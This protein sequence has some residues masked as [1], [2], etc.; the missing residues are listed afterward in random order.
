MN[1]NGR[2]AWIRTSSDLRTSLEVSRS[3]RPRLS[4]PCRVLA[5]LRAREHFGLRR[6]PTIHRFPATKS[7]CVS[8]IRSRLPLRGSPGVAPGSLCSLR[9]LREPAYVAVYCGVRY[10]STA[11]VWV[12]ARYGPISM[13]VHAEERESPL[14]LLGFYSPAW[15]N[16]WPKPESSDR[17]KDRLRR[18]LGA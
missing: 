4:L 1:E 18:A 11:M 17:R 12:M 2:G 9:I 13:I 7:Q 6:I 14:L 15:D 8:W 10:L 3:N 16:T 5:G